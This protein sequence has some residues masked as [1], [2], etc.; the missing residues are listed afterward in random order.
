MIHITID[1]P[2]VLAFFAGRIAY[3]FAKTWV[4]CRMPKN[5]TTPDL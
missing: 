5:N 3:Q 2:A 4:A 1:W